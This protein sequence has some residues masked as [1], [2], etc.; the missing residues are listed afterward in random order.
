MSGWLLCNRGDKITPEMGE[1]RAKGRV[2]GT[3]G[4][5]GRCRDTLSGMIL[6]CNCG[7]DRVNIKEQQ[8]C[9]VFWNCDNHRERMGGVGWQYQVPSHCLD[10]VL[11]LNCLSYLISPQPGFVLYRE[12]PLGGDRGAQSGVDMYS[13]L[14]P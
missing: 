7:E 10:A 12:L 6:K 13:S 9:Q 1:L 14:F 8:I 2:R 5:P 11:L 4:G 3:V